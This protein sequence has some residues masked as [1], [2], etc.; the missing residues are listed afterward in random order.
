MSAPGTTR[1]QAL[2]LLGVTL[3]TGCGPGTPGSQAPAQPVDLAT[4]LHLDPAVGTVPAAGLVWLVDTRPREVLASPP[5]IP[6]VALLL[7]E[8]TFDAFAARHGGLDLREIVDLAVAGYPDTFL[9][10]ARGPID[11]GRVESAFGRRALPVE[12][13]ASSHGVTRLWGS[14]AKDREQIALFGRQAVAFEH[15][16]LGPLRA[17]VYF[18]EGKLARAQPALAAPPLLEAAQK[19]GPAP[20]RAFAPGP[21]DG[22]MGRGL[23]GLLRAS[24]ALAIAAW[25]AAPSADHPSGLRL[26]V[27]LMGAW[28]D[29]ASAATERLR[30]AFDLLAND[31]LGRLSGLDHPLEGPSVWARDG[32]LGLDVTLDAMA[33]A[34]GLH[35][36]T[37]ATV[38]ELMAQ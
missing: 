9:A 28:G 29:D 23:G 16:R 8:S 32:A 22:A 25:P 12:G 34:R 15:G 19:L 21:F 18:A 33:L 7:P 27:L 2:A 11:P 30:A 38:T 4:D 35:D 10:V 24:T 17:A 31:V 1:R 6:A 36:V 20:L 14:V 26:R 3:A 37:T 13:R 5:L